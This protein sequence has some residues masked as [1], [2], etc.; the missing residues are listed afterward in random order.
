[1][2]FL[3]FVT[4]IQQQADLSTF[5]PVLIYVFQLCVQWS[6]FFNPV[7]EDVSHG[8]RRL[9]KA[10]MEA[11]WV[12]LWAVCDFKHG[13]E[14]NAL[15]SWWEKVTSEQWN[16]D[17]QIEALIFWKSSSC[18]YPPMYPYLCL[19]LV[20]RPTSQMALTFFSRNPISLLR[21]VMQSFSTTNAN[22]GMTPPSV[23]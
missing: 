23:G 14:A 20:L 2:W 13:L 22:A 21:M 19:P 18:L 6:V 9:V 17:I 1:M 5:P 16:L 12:D 7:R 3:F 11:I 15:L 8:P 4:S 10:Q